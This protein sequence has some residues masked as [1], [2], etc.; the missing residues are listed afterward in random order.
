MDAR[1]AHT[2]NQINR[3]FYD[4]FAAS[5]S[6]TRTAA[7]PGWER[8]VGRIG[9]PLSVL[10]LASGNQRFERFIAMSGPEFDT[11]FYCVDICEALSRDGVDVPGASSIC[12]QELDVVDAVLRGR[13]LTALIEAPDCDLSVA[14][15]FM[16]HVPGADAR[17][18]V[19]RS[20][21]DKTLPGGFVAVSFWRFMDEPKLAAKARKTTERALVNLDV[22]LDEGD[23]L[24]GWQDREGALR[25][26]HHFEDDEVDALVAAVASDVEVVDRFV[27]DG[28]TDALNAYL[29]LRKD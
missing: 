22:Q 26:C 5:F 8:I 10:D 7:W 19:L 18:A 4:T 15:G 14:F 24:L 2:L 3:T 9:V 20:L 23:Y 16:H 1:S 13:D 11:A 25:Y 12:L 28:R 21:V 6:E 27:A 17:A 29:L